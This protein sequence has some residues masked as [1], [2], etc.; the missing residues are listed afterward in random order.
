MKTELKHTITVLPKHCTVTAYDGETLLDALARGGV[1]IPAACAG[2]GTCGKCKVK[3]AYGN[4]G[5]EEPDE[6]GYI[7]SCHAKVTEDISILVSKENIVQSTKKTQHAPESL[8]VALDIGTTTLAA[9][10]IDLDTNSTLSECSCLNP[11]GIYGADVLTRITAAKGGKLELLQKLIIDKTREIITTL[12]ENRAVKKLIVSANTTMLHLF[13]GV[14]PENIGVYPFTPV[15]TNTETRSGKEL[16]LPAEKV[17]LL[18]SAGAYIGSDVTAGVLLTRLH[19]EKES[20]L[21]IDVGTNG[22]IVLSK[23][24]K[25]Y[26]S[27]TAAGPALEG[28]SIECGVGGI[29]GAI[30]SVKY[31][32]GDITFTTIEGKEPV[33]I[34]GS[35]L[36]DA[37]AILVES[38][39][40]DETGALCI[41]ADTPLIK[42][43]KDERFYISES[44]YIS[45]R[46]VR[47]FQ[48]AKS[49]ISAG[50]EALLTEKGLSLSEVKKVYIAGGLGSFMNIENAAR[51]GL[52]PLEFKEKTHI[53]GNTSLNGAILA[54]CDESAISEIENI[55]ERIELV[56]LSF[57]EVFRDKYM[58]RMYF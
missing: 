8:A 17:C 30:N 52:L 20:A 2:N 40:I 6:N 49:A 5:D 1:F 42:R 48:L 45:G 32:S 4:V 43:L 7:L 12:S 3:L 51:V 34:C 14:N 36:I 54:S 37:I 9:A 28:A 15:F 38:G 16:S 18:S 44:V 13:L 19:E 29:S 57:S 56:E 41:D 53:V 21:L 26:A 33:G 22:E 25:L 46:D 35:G 55:A 23:S 27:S 47:Q 58:E 10:L 31:E 11:Q 24:G 39:I 50:V